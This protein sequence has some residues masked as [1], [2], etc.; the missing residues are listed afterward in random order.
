MFKLQPHHKKYFCQDVLVLTNLDPIPRK[1]AHKHIFL[2]RY[3]YNSC[4]IVFL[5]AGRAVPS[6]GIGIGIRHYFWF[7]KVYYMSTNS[8]VLLVYRVY[9]YV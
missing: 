9:Y 8:V 2:F 3:S 5:L 4:Y 1:Y 7:G 6:T